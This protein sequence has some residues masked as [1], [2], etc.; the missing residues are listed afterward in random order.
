MM[1]TAICKLH[2]VLENFGKILSSLILTA[3]AFDRFV[4]VCHPQKKSLRSTKFAII[5]LLGLAAY[6][7]VTLF[8]LLLSFTI[9]ENIL[10]EKETA[11]FKVTRMK[12]EKVNVSSHNALMFLV[13]HASSILTGVCPIYDLLVRAVLFAASILGHVLL[14]STV[15]KA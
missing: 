2:A 11:P 4:G 5:I 9:N 10:Y 7:L 1:G 3:M 15:G 13:L 8:P 12:I 6:A 14:F